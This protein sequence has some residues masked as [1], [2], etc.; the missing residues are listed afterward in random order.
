[1]KIVGIDSLLS[2]EWKERRLGPVNMLKEQGKLEAAEAQEALVNFITNLGGI[3]QDVYEYLLTPRFADTNAVV[4]VRTLL[5]YAA[6]LEW[7]QL[8]VKALEKDAIAGVMFVQEIGA[9]YKDG[10]PLQVVEQFLNESD[11]AFEMCQNR[12]T[13]VQK[14][15][16]SMAGS[17]KDIT[18]EHSDRMTGSEGGVMSG[19]ES[20]VSDLAG[21]LKDT[22]SEAMREAVEELKLDLAGHDDR[23][24][25][26]VGDVIGE[27]G[28]RMTGSGEDAIG[29]HHDKMAEREEDGVVEHG[30]KVTG[31]RDAVIGEHND[32]MTGS[33]EDG[34]VEHGDKVTGSKD[35]ATEEHHDNLTGSEE[36][37]MEE[38]HDNLTESGE[39]NKSDGHALMKELE[40]E[41]RMM[42]ERVSFFHILLNRHMK[43]AFQ[44]MDE[45]SQITKI[46]EVMVQKRFHKDKIMSIKKLLDGDMPREF[47]FSL[48][49]K[50]LSAEELQDLC[51][52][53]LE[54]KEEA[55]DDGPEQQ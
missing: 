28:D 1:M 52:T 30:D 15:R 13:Y 53:L 23:V 40:E 29:E 44:K 22:V 17:E 35:N 26:S 6:P 43:K 34:V 41:E 46:F 51:E 5:C 54:N 32:R 25:G 49:D 9:A 48:L 10:M 42:K 45:K 38:Y 55:A 50:D 14:E 18:G 8:A 24:T 3:R 20:L 27:H 47:I 33:G 21:M 2:E 39:A 11:T 12:F 4:S 19:S 36:D 7:I 31:S 16:S 37:S